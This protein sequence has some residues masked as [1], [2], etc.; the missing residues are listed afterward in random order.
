MKRSATRT[1]K[2]AALQRRMELLDDVVEYLLN[3][4]LAGLSL[5]PLAAGINTS[6]RMLLYFFGSKEQLIS[7]ALAQIRLRQ[8]AD[9]ARA[10]AGTG[11]RE[12]RLIR[13][14]RAWSSP[15]TERFWRFWFGVYGTALHDPERYAGFLERF[16]GEWL[17]PFELALRATGLPRARARCL[18]TLS[19]SAMRGL[20]LDL[21]ASGARSRI[22]AAF[23]ELLGLLTLAI[24][25]AHDADGR[26]PHSGELPKG[27]RSPIGGKAHS[28]GG[29]RRRRITRS[30]AID[31]SQTKD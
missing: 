13:A 19:L 29:A 4:G 3:N 17:A 5:R 20:Q 27:A 1:R 10:I 6:P 14:W 28:Q 2:S 22:D 26:T 31:E 9:F 16:V 15:R 8:R 11:D 30:P 24:R 12:Q 7:E 21:L 25:E 18:A 23:R